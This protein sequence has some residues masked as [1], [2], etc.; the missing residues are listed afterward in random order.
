[1][2]RSGINKYGEPADHYYF[3]GDFGDKPNDLDF[4]AMVSLLPTGGLP[5]SYWK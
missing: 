2:G 4:A 1:M 3:G 5:Q